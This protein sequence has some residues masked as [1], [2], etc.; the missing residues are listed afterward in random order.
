M[1]AYED[2]GLVGQNAGFGSTEPSNNGAAT[3][4]LQTI[5]LAV[6]VAVLGMPPVRP[7]SPM[8][9]TAYM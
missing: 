2:G 1:I 7:K 8:M 9:S 5:F 3:H 4:I 6:G